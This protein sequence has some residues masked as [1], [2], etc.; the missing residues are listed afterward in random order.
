MPSPAK[1]SA[2]PAAPDMAPQ[3]GAAPRLQGCYSLLLKPQRWPSEGITPQS[4]QGDLCRPGAAAR[5][6]TER[7]SVQWGT[8][9]AFSCLG[10]RGDTQTFQL[11]LQDTHV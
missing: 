2:C 1:G 8:P 10:L 9:G 5:L 4:G 3:L 11:L 7:Q 6:G